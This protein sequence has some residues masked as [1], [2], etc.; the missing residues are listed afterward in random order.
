M[1]RPVRR[2]LPIAAAAG[3]C[4]LIGLF[5]AI[6]YSTHRALNRST[7]AVDRQHRLGFSLRPIDLAAARSA[8]PGFEPV[9]ASPSF[10]SGAILGDRLYL[11]SAAGLGIYSGDGTLRQLLRTG[12]ELPAATLGPITTGRLR[13]ASSPQVLV[14]TQGAG[15]FILTPAPDGTLTLTQLLPDDLS[16]R[17][18][19]A[20]LVTASG[21]LLL[22]TRNHGLQLF[23][24]ETLAPVTLPGAASARLPI[25]ALA[26][27]GEGVLIGTRD[28]GVFWQHAGTTEQISLAEGLPDAQVES[29][30]TAPDGRS[31]IGTP[32]GIA[33]LD[34][35]APGHPIEVLAAGIFAHTLAFDATRHTLLAG[36]LDQGLEEIPLERRARLRNAS[37]TAPAAPAEPA[38]AEAIAALIPNPAGTQPLAITSAAVLTRGPAGRWSPA[39]HTASSTLTD[40]NIAALAFAPDGK[41]W[42]G[43]FDRGL[44]QLNPDL[45]RA[46][47]L[48]DDHLFC[49]NRL[50][51]DPVRHT[52]AA[53]TANGLVLFDTAGHPRQTL[54]RRDGLISDHV[55]D[56][57]FTASGLAV[58]T[59]AGISFLEPAGTSS[60][61]AFQ[62][63]V[64]NHVYTL[65][66]SG[67][68]LLAGTLGGLSVLEGGQVRRNLT[69]TNSGLRHNWITAILPMP[70]EHET[71]WLI[72]TYGAGLERLSL[73]A[74]GTATVT[75]V[76]TPPDL[77]AGAPRDLV[78]NP[79][80]ILRTPTAIY[81]GTLGHGMLVY[82]V[83]AGRWSE[84][85]AGLPSTNVTAFAARGQASTAELFIG[86]DAGLVHIAEPHLLVFLNGGAQR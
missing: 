2:L 13:S 20:L 58:A 10:T 21:D 19:T 66:S 59:P 51:V 22:G 54:T 68:E 41:L 25:T 84:V 31:W 32:A 27:A 4:A 65:A 39:F 71:A 30:A 50:A 9:A 63:L 15:V 64:N 29:L 60:L 40:S 72:G 33:E 78:I 8:G 42:V 48:E 57:A 12:L 83:A 26:A 79:N 61:Y 38:S 43:F 75:P 24:G 3:A 45:T 80:A 17:D 18:L 81:A 28:A 44:D 53:A 1:S 73:N 70:A 52:L 34:L 67:N 62:G 23:N 5:L 6:V 86:T 7:T 49:L 85:T 46:A 36:T 11:A 76:F 56:L 74:A 35:N 77:P 37:I 14:A 16:L 82:S 47:H 55:N 69:A